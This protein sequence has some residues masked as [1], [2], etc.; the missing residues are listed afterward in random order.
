MCN[1]MKKFRK[2]L[3]KRGIAWEDKSDEMIDRVH[4]Y[5]R[6]QKWSVI[7]GLGTYGGYLFDFQHNQDLL[8]IMQINSNE[9][10]IGFLTAKQAIKII[11][12]D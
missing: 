3:D 5:N 11:I 4:F 2:E 8:E 12:G 10:P 6:D 9:E 1:E 7:N